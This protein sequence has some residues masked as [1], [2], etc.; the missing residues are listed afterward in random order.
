MSALLVQPKVHA[1]VLFDFGRVHATG[2][3]PQ[4]RLFFHGR[5]QVGSIRQLNAV[6]VTVRPAAVLPHPAVPA[7][8]GTS[9]GHEPPRASKGRTG[10]EEIPENEPTKTSV[11]WPVPWR[12]LQHLVNLW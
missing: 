8:Q 9:W 2:R 1:Y 7:L 10:L 11:Q 3:A 5:K 4:K 12:K 6:G